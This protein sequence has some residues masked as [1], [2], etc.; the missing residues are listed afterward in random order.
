MNLAFPS[1]GVPKLMVRR[2]TKARGT[3]P[4]NIYFC[5]FFC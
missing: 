1:N 5:F 3:L 2:C 4:P